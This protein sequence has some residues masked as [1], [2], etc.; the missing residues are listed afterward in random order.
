MVL[1][2][3]VYLF[4]EA[5]GGGCCKL[6]GGGCSSPGQPKL[7]LSLTIVFLVRSRAPKRDE[8]RGPDPKSPSQSNAISL[9]FKIIKQICKPCFHCISLLHLAS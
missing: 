5:W 9:Y 2:L 1:T 6:W 4:D 7:F 3:T 8:W